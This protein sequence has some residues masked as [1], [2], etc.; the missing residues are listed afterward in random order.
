MYVRRL[1]YIQRSPWIPGCNMFSRSPA[2]TGHAESHIG[3]D[4]CLGCIYLYNQITLSIQI[5]ESM[6]TRL[7]CSGR[8]KGYMFRSKHAYIHAHGFTH[9]RLTTHACK[10]TSAHTH[11]FERKRNSNLGGIEIFRVWFFVSAEEFC[12]LSRRQ[13]SN[14]IS[15]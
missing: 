10:C 14:L 11:T 3:T 5:P 6:C 13:N 12:K 7:T 1:Y 2:A 15:E 4:V 8:S 9:I